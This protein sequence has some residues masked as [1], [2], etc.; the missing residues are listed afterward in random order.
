V[1][2][3]GVGPVIETA[4]K[5][6]MAWHPSMFL[7][8]VTELK[9][10]QAYIGGWNRPHAARARGPC[11]YEH[12]WHRPA[13]TRTLTPLFYGLNLR[14][15][16]R[17]GTVLYSHAVCN[18]STCLYTTK[19]NTHG[20]TLV[21]YPEFLFK[22][23]ILILEAAQFLFAVMSNLNKSRPLLPAPRCPSL[24]CLCSCCCQCPF[25]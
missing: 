2:A 14:H 12:S 21:L 25:L 3:D 7:Q 17:S 4:V 8:A 19:H 22:F 13:H 6:L 11:G 20:G 24:G 9:G 15:Y 23:I 5:Q 18:I 16:R 1:L 10:H